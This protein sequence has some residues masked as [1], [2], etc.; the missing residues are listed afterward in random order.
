MENAKYMA[1]KGVLR[2]SIVTSG[3]AL[4]KNDIDN[5]CTAVKEI[6]SQCS[7]S[8]CVSL[9][10]ISDD[11]FKKIKA[12]GVERIHNNIETSKNYFP[13]ICSTH[14]I[15]DKITALK[16]AKS[17]GF[18]ICSGIIIGLGESMQD[19]IDA[20]F[21]L[22]DLKVDSVPLNILNGIKGTPYENNK[23]LS[24][25]EILKTCALFRFILPDVYLRLAGGRI[26]LLDFGEKTIYAGVNAFITGDM[27]TTNGIS[28][29]KDL[30][31]IEKAG[32]KLGY[33]F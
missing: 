31:I 12:A 28:C 8:V 18:S 7:I 3:R 5:I 14:T 17:H 4:T 19:R 26:Q 32:Y 22:R 15:D 6:K 10:L 25:K 2:F 21:L 24:E 13:N 1:S 20:A 30:K 29:D 33:N 27:L 11:D 16:K 9:G 23:K